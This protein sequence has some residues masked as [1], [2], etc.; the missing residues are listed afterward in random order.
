MIRIPL[1][2]ACALLVSVLPM[3]SAEEN[4]PPPCERPAAPDEGIRCN[5]MTICF[6][7]AFARTPPVCVST[8]P[9]FCGNE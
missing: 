2:L 7:N 3:A 8:D 4:E 5:S 1:L 9:A 6:D